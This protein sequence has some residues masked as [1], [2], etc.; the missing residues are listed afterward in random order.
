MGM[1]PPT[2]SRRGAFVFFCFLFFVLP[3]ATKAATEATEEHK[4]ESPRQQ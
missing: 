3:R 1:E 4:S 2:A